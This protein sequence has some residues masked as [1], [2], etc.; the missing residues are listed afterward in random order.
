MDCPILCYGEIDLDWYLAV[1]ALPGADRDA[2][3][4]QEIHNVGGAAA[5]AAVWLAHWGIPVRLAGLDLGD[6]ADG[7]FIRQQLACYP[8]LDSHYICYRSDQPTPRCQCLVTPD[9]ER[10]FIVHWPDDITMTP[11]SSAMLQGVRWLNLDMSGALSPR[12]EAAQLARAHGA[13]VLVNDI[14]SADHPLLAYTDIVVLSAALFDRQYSGAS[15]R[16]VLTSMRQASN[17]DVI[18]TN[19]S[20]PVWT[21]LKDGSEITVWPPSIQVV[22]TTGAGDVFKAGLLYGLLQENTVR[23]SLI[24]A[25]AAATAKA[26]RAGTTTAPADLSTVQQ[27]AMMICAQVHK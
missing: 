19:G 5:N 14:Y 18:V 11:L 23:Q 27:L 12:L 9:G 24:W 4:R 17:C 2:H 16:E 1:D 21:M 15:L 6:D 22:D 10:S 20:Q 25:V 7:A 13:S 8:L 26:G 3:V